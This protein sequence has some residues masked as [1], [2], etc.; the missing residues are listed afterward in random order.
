MT[1]MAQMPSRLSEPLVRASRAAP[2]RSPAHLQH[3][4]LPSPLLIQLR[5]AS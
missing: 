4:R 1:Q 3:L 5:A 2:P